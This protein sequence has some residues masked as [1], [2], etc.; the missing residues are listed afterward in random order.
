MLPTGTLAVSATD[1]CNNLNAAN[2]DLSGDPK[3]TYMLQASGSEQTATLSTLNTK[4]YQLRY[5]SGVLA[6]QRMLETGDNIAGY[7]APFPIPEV[8]RQINA[9][10]LGCRSVNPNCVVKMLLTQTWAD[11]SIELA[12]AQKLWVEDNARIIA[13]NS[14]SFQGHGFLVDQQQQGCSFN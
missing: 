4:I 6:G 12:G 7:L 2:G 5:V 14:D 11:Q 8:F 9:F 1:V 10:A 13:Q 3:I